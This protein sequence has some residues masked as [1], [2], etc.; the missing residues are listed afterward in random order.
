VKGL[1]CHQKS[2]QFINRNLDSVTSNNPKVFVVKNDEADEV[3]SC[4]GCKIHAEVGWHCPDCR[5]LKSI[6]QDGKIN[7]VRTKRNRT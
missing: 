5:F 7:V 1:V 3:S 4:V 2:I 6:E